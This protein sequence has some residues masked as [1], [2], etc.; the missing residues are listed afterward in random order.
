M[1][2]LDAV[3]D[4]QR[5]YHRK[6]A[7]NRAWYDLGMNRVH[8]AWKYATFALGVVVVGQFFWWN[9]KAPEVLRLGGYAG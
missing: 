6:A 4:A 2:E 7:R 1:N 3:T 8:P 5:P 9:A